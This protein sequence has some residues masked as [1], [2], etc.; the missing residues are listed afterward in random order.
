MKKMVTK[1][2]KKDEIFIHVDLFLGNGKSKV[3][4]CD[5]N[6]KIYR[7]KCRL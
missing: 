2:L 6:K 3:W 5:L 1:H 7:N 4:T